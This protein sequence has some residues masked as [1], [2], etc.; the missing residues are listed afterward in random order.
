MKL[1]YSKIH[2]FLLSLVA[3]SILSASFGASAERPPWKRSG[4]KVKVKI[5]SAPSGAKIYIEDKKWGI[6]ATTP[7]KW[8]RL[9]RNNSYKVILTHPDMKDFVTTIQ[10]TRRY[11]N[12]FTFTMTKKIHKGHLEFKDGG[13]GSSVGAQVFIDGQ[14]KGTM[15]IKI[16]VLPGKYSIKIVKKGYVDYKE[17]RTVTEKTTT[18]LL[19][20]LS[21]VVIPKGSLIVSSDVD[22]AEVFIDKVSRGYTP[23]LIKLLPGNHLV[24]VKHKKEKLQKIV[25]IKPNETSK[26]NAKLKPT[27]PDIPQ[28][29]ITVITDTTGCDVYIDGMLKGKTPLPR[30][31]ILVGQHLIEV[32]KTGFVSQKRTITV[33]ANQ[34]QLVTFDIKAE[35]KII[36]IGSLKI[37][38]E[39]GA[40]IFLDG[41]PK[42]K[43]SFFMEKIKAGSY[44]LEITKPGYKKVN[45][46]LIVKKGKG[47]NL[48]VPLDRVGNLK[49]T[50]NVIG[51]SIIIDNNIIGKVPLLNHELPVGTY[52]L[53]IK[54]K[55]YRLYTRTIAIKGGTTEP[56]TLNVNLI[57]LEPTADEIAEMKS[58]LSAFGA[59]VIPPRSFTASAGTGF[60][61]I[62]EGKLMVGIWRKGNL[63]IDGGATLRTYF[64][65]TEILFNVRA[66]LWQ[67]GP[68]TLGAFTEMGG[69]VGMK[70]RVN[71]TWNLGAS[72]T[73]SFREKVNL[74]L[75]GY[76][77]IYRDRF[78]LAGDYDPDDPRTELSFCHDNTVNVDEQ[79]GGWAG[80]SLREP[81]WGVRFMFMATVEW[82]INTK[83]SVY[84]NF[85]WAAIPLKPSSTIYRPAFMDQYGTDLMPETDPTFYGGAGAI[86]KF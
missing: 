41:Q 7:S 83:L 82:A 55:G 67:G 27:D 10:L 28:G 22:K 35:P 75:S 6:V 46:T 36:P 37:T 34:Q 12:R 30:L 44:Q 19:I 39:T 24:V 26:V 20:V 59:K 42:G 78:C 57:S 32:R 40:Q 69:G 38:T 64:T 84:A 72:G 13:T 58:S 53:E 74:S 54:A 9:P 80:H 29:L 3:I 16:D 48:H 21:K 31:K 11:R 5:K 17:I 45:K 8:I 85:K 23:L 66:Q 61:Y 52:R 63:G 18:S 47:T 14:L 62:F 76:L 25:E 2:T 4:R 15:P 77:N 50:A 60:P 51:A 1:N 33:N 65:M 43:S 71:F 68:L 81:Y 79:L 86:W 49:I 73:L 56:V 70:E